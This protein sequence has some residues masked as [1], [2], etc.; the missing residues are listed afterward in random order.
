MKNDTKTFFNN[1]EG[2]KRAKG[3]LISNLDFEKYTSLF[4]KHEWWNL[5][6][7]LDLRS[8]ARTGL[9]VRDPPRV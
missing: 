8:S 5:A 4:Y 3:V 7:T 2:F 9:R 1:R 6:Y